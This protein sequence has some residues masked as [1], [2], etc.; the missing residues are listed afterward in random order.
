MPNKQKKNKVISLESLVGKKKPSLEEID[1]WIC[2]LA[3]KTSSEGDGKR[4][5]K[6]SRTAINR[7]VL[8]SL[9]YG[10]LK[11]DVLKALKL[12]K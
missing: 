4:W 9:I 3:E 11:I 5:T 7:W 8:R 2:Q 10:K 6:E 1:A 12:L